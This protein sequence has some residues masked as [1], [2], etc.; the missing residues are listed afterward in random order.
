MGSDPCCIGRGGGISRFYPPTGWPAFGRRHG[1]CHGAT[2][3]WQRHVGFPDYHTHCRRSSRPPLPNR[4]GQRACFT[5][6]ACWRFDEG[7]ECRE[8]GVR[9]GSISTTC[10]NGERYTRP[11]RSYIRSAGFHWVALVLKPRTTRPLGPRPTS[12]RRSRRLLTLQAAKAV[13]MTAGTGSYS[14]DTIA[15]APGPGMSTSRA[16]FGPG[17]RQKLQSW[18]G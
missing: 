1:R 15:P 18:M 3:D 17:P 5:W 4:G 8:A 2:Q 7:S 12:T 14:Q 6:R 9:V 11:P 10:G 13:R 16:G